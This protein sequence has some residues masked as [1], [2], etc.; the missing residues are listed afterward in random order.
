MNGSVVDQDLVAITVVVDSD[1]RIES[2]KQPF[3]RHSL[4]FTPR[5]MAPDDGVLLA[6]DADLKKDVVS[7]TDDIDGGVVDIRGRV[8]RQ[9]QFRGLEDDDVLSLEF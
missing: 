6:T 5:A 8:R 3:K 4:L 7:G 2:D 1:G 9:V